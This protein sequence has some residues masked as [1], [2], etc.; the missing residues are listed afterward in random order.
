MPLYSATRP[1]SW[2]ILLFEIRSWFFFFHFFSFIVS[3]RVNSYE[4][5]F[6]ASFSIARTC[7]WFRLRESPMEDEAAIAPRISILFSALEVTITFTPRDASS[8][9]S[10]R[11]ISHAVMPGPAC[12]SRSVT[13]WLKMLPEPICA[14]GRRLNYCPMHNVVFLSSDPSIATP[15]Q[16][17]EVNT[18][19]L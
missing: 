12:S 3:F 16:G 7:G 15:E 4:G 2:F 9:H 17:I 1:S 18:V 11:N 13:P 5:S 14:A 8:M 19:G 6:A 10:G